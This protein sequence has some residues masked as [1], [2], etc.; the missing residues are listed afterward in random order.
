MPLLLLHPGDVFCVR[1]PGALGVIIR[2]IQ[3]FNSRDG[4]APYNHAGIITTAA[5]DIIEAHWRIRKASIWQ[6]EG[7][8]ILI[9][10]YL[11]L[12]RRRHR[13]AM[14]IIQEKYLGKPYPAWRLFLHLVPPLAKFLSTRRHAVCSE[15]P[16]E[17]LYLVGARHRQ[18][19]GTTPDILAD[20][21][22]RWQVH[23]VLFEGVLRR[24]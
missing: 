11:G 1:S 8:R 5:G 3:W 19:P 17:Y 10:R 4:E 18:W 15:L 22:R 13:S 2:G 23:K 12:T 14:A 24:P 16:A 20:E 9:G 21:L 7:Q 6:Y